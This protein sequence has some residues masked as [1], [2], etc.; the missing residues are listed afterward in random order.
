MERDGEKRTAGLKPYEEEVLE[1]MYDKRIIGAS[2]YE[3]RERVRSKIDW[4]EI[5]RKHRVRKRFRRVIKH[6]CAKGFVSDWGKSGDVA[7]LT[8]DGVLYVR[9]MILQRRSKQKD[10]QH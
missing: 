6:L 4:Q 3:P 1:Q 5:A 2:G 7:S 8:Q 10:I 9:A